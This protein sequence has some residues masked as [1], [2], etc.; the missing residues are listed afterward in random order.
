MKESLVTKTHS[1]ALSSAQFT[2]HHS[3]TSSLSQGKTTNPLTSKIASVL[4]TSYT[5]SDFRDTLDLFDKR[6]LQHHTKIN[7]RLRL[8]LHKEV[9]DRNSDVLN[10]FG[11]VAEVWLFKSPQSS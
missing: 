3:G 10:E 4:S 6:A 7:R 1:N 2:A 9:I 5:D 8:D 11:K